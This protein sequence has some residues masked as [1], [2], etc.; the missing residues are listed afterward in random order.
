MRSRLW[1]GHFSCNAI[2]DLTT[3]AWL[4]WAGCTPDELIADDWALCHT[5]GV[6]LVD[7]DAHTLVAPSAALPNRLNL[8]VFDRLERG[9]W[10]ESSPGVPG[11]E[12]EGCRGEIESDGGGDHWLDG[13][14]RRWCPVACGATDALRRKE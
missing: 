8:V 10:H 9:D 3:E 1:V 12:H 13:R 11:G 4:A 14:G 7:C 5:L 2:A 6:R